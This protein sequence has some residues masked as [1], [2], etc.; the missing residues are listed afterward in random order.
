M[1]KPRCLR[2]PQTPSQIVAIDA[3]AESPSAVLM[4]LVTSTEPIDEPIGAGAA[5]IERSPELAHRVA[6]LDVHKRAALDDARLAWLLLRLSPFSCGLKHG[7][8]A[9]AT[10]RAESPPRSPEQHPRYSCALSMASIFSRTAR[11]DCLTTI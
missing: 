8:A 4:R 7:P 1:T 10:G 2:S 9:L 6:G 5:M 3:T 11:K